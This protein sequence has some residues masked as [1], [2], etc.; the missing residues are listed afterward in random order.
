VHAGGDDRSPLPGLCGVLL[1]LLSVVIRVVWLLG[2]H[3]STVAALLSAMLLSVVIR[4]V[5]VQFSSVQ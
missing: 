4:V 5:S 3:D 1:L 2:Q